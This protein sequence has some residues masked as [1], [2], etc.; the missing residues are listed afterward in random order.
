MKAYTSPMDGREEMRGWE[1][2]LATL[3]LD[4]TPFRLHLRLEGLGSVSVGYVNDIV[5][6]D[7][8]SPSLTNVA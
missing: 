8:S 6:H 7:D 1:R 4:D 2:C 3:A 5:A